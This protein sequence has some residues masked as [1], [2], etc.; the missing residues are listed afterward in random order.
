[1]EWTWWWKHTGIWAFT[2]IINWTDNTNALRKKGQSRLFLLRTFFDS[3]VASA[4]WSGLLGQQHLDCLQEGWPSTQD[5][6][7]AQVEVAGGG[8][9]WLSFHPRLRTC[10]TPMQ[11][12]STGQLIQWQAALPCSG[13]RRDKAGLSCGCQ[14]LQST[15][16]PVDH[17]PNLTLQYEQ[18]LNCN[19]V[20]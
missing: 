19:N 2:W 14:I 8:E 1:M 9:W 12:N 20:I 6:A 10:P 18:I 4:I 17:T 15:L 7:R 13:L 3:V 16:L 11:S 5:R